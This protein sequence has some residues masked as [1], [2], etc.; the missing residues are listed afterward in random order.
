MLGVMLQDKL[1]ESALWMPALWMPKPP[2]CTECR[3]WD[4][5]GET[6]WDKARFGCPNPWSVPD[7][8]LYKSYVGIKLVEA[9]VRCWDKYGETSWD[10]A[11][12]GC[13][14]RLSVPDDLQ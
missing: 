1:G 5:Y 14:N 11:R 13:P 10:K 8:L 4:K 9:D 3:C 7:D 2:A 12:F 6:S